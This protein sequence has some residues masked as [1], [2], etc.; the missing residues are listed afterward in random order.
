MILDSVIKEA[1]ASARDNGVILVGRVTVLGHPVRY[2]MRH[3]RT[4]EADGYS[5]EVI[6]RGEHAI[7]MVACDP[8][9]AREIFLALLRGRVTPCSFTYI[10]QEIT[11]PGTLVNCIPPK[12]KILC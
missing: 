8:G 3:T 1:A 4:S 5:F 12:N 9:Q 7:C 11:E 2:E 10:M 6:Y